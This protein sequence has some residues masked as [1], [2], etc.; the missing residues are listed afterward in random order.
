M[1]VRRLEDGGR[2]VLKRL[3]AHLLAC[4]SSG[5]PS[6]AAARLTSAAFVHDVECQREVAEVARR[7]LPTL[8]AEAARAFTNLVREGPPYEHVDDPEVIERYVSYWRALISRPL[9][10]VAGD[11][12]GEYRG[13]ADAHP[14][15]DVFRPRFQ[16]HSLAGSS[17]SWG[18]GTSPLTEDELRN[19]PPGDLATMLKS[20]VPESEFG[21]PTIGGLATVLTM[22]IAA[23]PAATV[24]HSTRSP[25]FRRHSG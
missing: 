4:D 21:S 7:Y 2:T 8:S 6:L 18:N 23:D 16:I 13:W 22:A 10:D 24:P 1:V 12:V 25:M 14:D 5:N 17:G 20:W 11:S 19:M 15:A 9:V 3:A